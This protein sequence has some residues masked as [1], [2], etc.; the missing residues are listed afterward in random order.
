MAEETT[1]TVKFADKFESP[2][3]FSKGINEARTKLGLDPHDENAPP[4]GEG[5]VYATVEIA[6][7]AYKDFEKLIHS[8][9]KPKEDPK[10]KPKDT[11]PSGLKLASD[12]VEPDD[13]ATIDQ[14]LEKAGLDGEELATTFKADGKLS[15]EQYAKLNKLGY[16]KSAVNAFMQ[17]QQST[18]ALAEAEQA[19]MRK[20]GVAIAGGNE[21]WENLTAWAK[22]NYDADERADLDE[23]LAKPN[24]YKG[25]IKQMLSDHREAM[26]AGKAQS[27]VSGDSPA[28]SGAGFTDHE[29]F[30]AAAEK[31]MTARQSGQPI[32]ALEKKIA[33]TDDSVINI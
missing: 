26:G 17:G 27:L 31:A 19:G 7:S 25:A 3:E 4:F 8:Q 18:A 24:R 20:S 1:V 12:P 9:A 10:P 32:V 30:V 14:V 29:E 16:P 21:Q 5:S 15:G 2:E 22:S 23:R 13:D 11:K 6:E 28:A 33:A